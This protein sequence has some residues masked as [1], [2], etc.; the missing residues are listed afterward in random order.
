MTS[1]SR[2]GPVDLA[3][4]A[5]VVTHLAGQ[6]DIRHPDLRDVVPLTGTEVAVIREIHRH[7]HSTP[8]QIAEATGLQRSNV[9][10]AVRTLEAGGLVVRGRV[11]DNAR[12]VTLAPTAKAAEHVARIHTYWAE[13]LAQAP[14]EALADAVSAVEALAAVSDALG[15][16]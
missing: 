11:P 7:P 12:S 4:L 14:A 15:R 13:R 10:T 6:L 1:T 9:S 8:T 3:R 2:P 5:D 16:D